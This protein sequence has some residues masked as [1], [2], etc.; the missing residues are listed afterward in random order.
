MIDFVQVVDVPIEEMTLEDI[1]TERAAHAWV[2][3]K[4]SNLADHLSVRLYWLREH[5]PYVPKEVYR[6]QYENG[7]LSAKDYRLT[8]MQMAKR[9]IY[10]RHC[11]AQIKYAT[12]LTD[13]ET[14][15]VNALD[16]RIEVLKAK[17]E[18]K[19]RGRKPR[20]PTKNASKNNRKP[21]QPSEE[22]RPAKKVRLKVTDTERKDKET[23]SVMRRMEA[24]TEWDA[25]KF[26]KVAES[27]GYQTLPSVY[28]A[29]SEEL[30]ITMGGAMR[31]LKYGK[32]SWGQIVVIASFFE[33][34][35]IEFCDVF[36]SGVFKE[37][38]D[39]KWV[40]TCDNKAALLDTPTYV[41]SNQPR[42]TEQGKE[43]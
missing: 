42:E 41:M 43:G 31:L 12:M 32:M 23:D 20:D 18:P 4:V 27:R 22:I 3:Y 6:A 36:L 35:P 17:P 25:D 24:I 29:V 26:F 8:A 38:V 37:A 16:E 21:W 2:R 33:M 13:H 34:T 14:A 10:H 19:K 15:V 40:A 39:G 30:N 7:E 28:A 9:K 11:E 5:K 1:K